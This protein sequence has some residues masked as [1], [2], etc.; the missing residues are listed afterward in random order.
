MSTYKKRIEK[1]LINYCHEF[2]KVLEGCLIPKASTS[3][4]RIFFYKQKGDYYRMLA[5]VVDGV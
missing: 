3:E 4:A 1:E 5:E 2:L